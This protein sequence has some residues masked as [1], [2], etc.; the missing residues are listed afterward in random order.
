MIA[1]PA[2]GVKEGLTIQADLFGLTTSRLVV[3]PLFGATCPLFAGPRDR[4][5]F[6]R[7]LC[8]GHVG[9]DHHRIDGI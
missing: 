8:R 7:W 3:L 9:H 5:T 4:I 6:R 2:H 1:L